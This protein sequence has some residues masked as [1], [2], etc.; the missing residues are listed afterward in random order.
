MNIESTGQKPYVHKPF[1]LLSPLFVA[2]AAGPFPQRIF[3]PFVSG[4]ISEEEMRV[5]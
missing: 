2:V 4:R 3:L 1:G 5:G